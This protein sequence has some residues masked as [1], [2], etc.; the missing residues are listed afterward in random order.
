M[1]DQPAPIQVEDGDFKGWYLSPFHDDYVNLIGPFYYQPDENG[2]MRV[3]LKVEQRHLNGGGIMHG[4]CLLSLA[5]TALFIIAMDENKT[6][7]GV[8]MQLDAQFVSPA[9]L[10]DIIIASGEVVRS[11]KSTIFVRGQITTNDTPVM[12][13]SGIIKRS[14]RSG[15]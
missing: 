15:A 6:S 8:T 1:A 13:F 14:S 5:D 3:A 7:G 12:A 9:N 4:G 10:G 11:G 2:Q